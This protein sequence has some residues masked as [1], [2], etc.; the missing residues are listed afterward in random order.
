[1][2]LK[3]IDQAILICKDHLDSS[4]EWGTEIETF[5]T[6][7]LLILIHAH[8]EEEI[9]KI[10]IKRHHA[11]ND[12]NLIS[13]SESS[14]KEKLRSIK[15]GDISKL[16]ILIN[17]EIYKKF[18]SKYHGSKEETSFSSIINQRHESAHKTG[19]FITMSLKDLIN[20]YESGHI[21]LDYLDDLLNN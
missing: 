11:T 6:R 15:V 19:T 8:F 17:I 3:V 12:S 7:Y 4:N 20:Y 16:L 14:I 18:K 1:M 2:K 10:F 5:L 21:I 13:F 9:Q